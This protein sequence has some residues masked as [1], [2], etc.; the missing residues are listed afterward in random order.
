MLFT[1]LNG[2]QSTISFVQEN[3]PLFTRFVMAMVPNTFPPMLTMSR[4]G[5]ITTRE[6]QKEIILLRPNPK[7]KIQA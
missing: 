1:Q 7:K 2:F 4:V 3:S 6:L 5:I